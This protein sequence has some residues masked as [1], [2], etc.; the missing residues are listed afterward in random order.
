MREADRF[1]RVCTR[2][3]SLIAILAIP[4]LPLHAAG[5]SH[6][7]GA[8]GEGSRPD[9]PVSFDIGPARSN[10]A[11]LTLEE[12]LAVARQNNPTLRAARTA[13]RLPEAD[14]A[15]AS[16][17]SNPF[18]GLSVFPGLNTGTGVAVSLGKRFEVA[19]QRGLRA[20]AARARIGAVSWQVT[21]AERT[22]RARVGQSFYSVRFSQEMVT[23]LDSVVEVT[24]LLLQAAQLKLEG[25]FA[26]ELDR[27]LARVELLRAQLQRIQASNALV[28]REAE[29]N[30]LLARP[31]GED[32]DAVGPL[33]YGPVP[34]ELSLERLQSFA[35]FARPDLQA[36]SELGRAASLGTALARRLA[37]PDLV[38]AADLVREA[39]GVRTVGLSVAA[40][41]PVFDRNQLGRDRALAREALVAA[42][43]EARALAVSQE[44]RGA[45]ARLN[46]ARVGLSTYQDDI[47]ALTETSQQFA[48]LAYARGELD[49]T[50][51]LLAQ[52]QHTDARVAYL[53]AALAFD[54]AAL[55]LE[56]ATGAPLVEVARTVPTRDEN[57]EK[58][59]DQ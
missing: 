27:N 20:D 1:A 2:T 11:S 49:I 23:V 31:A 5:Q 14:L 4:I 35:R 26:P 28:A 42:E 3:R 47:L 29:L 34:E 57:L 41:L 40:S 55:E 56:S 46:A 22:L 21:D 52:R 32:V 13:L 58:E 48:S 24:A 50:T 53:E 54:R 59:D 25:G 33:V 45:F 51:A 16:R 10:P 12:A 30:Q 37:A 17:F 36:V 9:I 38:L 19:G 6:T 39:D 7:L 18:I 44:V 15:Q 8:V 43:A